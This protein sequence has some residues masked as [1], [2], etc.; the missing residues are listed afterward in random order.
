MKHLTPLQLLEYRDG[1]R[2]DEEELHLPTCQECSEKLRALQ[3]V[4]EAIQRVELEKVSPNFTERVMTRLGVKESPS[5][6]WT[7]FQNLAPLFALLIVVGI[8]AAAFQLTGAYQSSDVQQS[9]RQAQSVYNE[10]SG[11][12]ATGIEALNGWLKQYASFAFAE[13]TTGLTIFL[14]AFF[15][16]TALLDKFLF[17]PLR[18]RK[19]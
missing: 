12:I 14:I 19:G 3:W 16:G 5:L 11:G 9:A 2:G 13:S 6:A 4:E 7:I 15:A 1:L 17:V 10:I 18:K 8:V